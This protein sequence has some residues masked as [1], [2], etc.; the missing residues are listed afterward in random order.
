MKRIILA[1]LALGTLASCGRQTMVSAEPTSPVETTTEPV[2]VKAATV[3]EPAVRLNPPTTTIPPI[4]RTGRVV[5]LGDS[6][7]WLLCQHMPNA[8]CQ[9]FPGGWVDNSVG[10]DLLGG[11][12]TDA[13]LQPGDVAIVSSAS[14]FHSTQTPDD[15]AVQQRLTA[16]LDRIVA[17]GAILVMLTPP[18]PGYPNCVL[19]TPEALAT[20]GANDVAASCA[21]QAAVAE[22]AQTYP[23]LH[24]P[25][26]GPFEPDLL[27]PSVEGLQILAGRVAGV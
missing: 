3:T 27:H 7:A 21:T 19:L 5:L 16:N 23:A 1:T 13:A 6:I 2:I 24:V 4:I 15:I 22:V 8:E 17:T 18:D 25:V 14:S 9:S 26:D 10:V 12:I 20:F 11:F